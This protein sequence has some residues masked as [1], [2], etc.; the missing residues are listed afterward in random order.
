MLQVR[1]KIKISRHILLV[2][3]VTEKVTFVKSKP[4]QEEFPFRRCPEPFLKAVKAIVDIRLV[5]REKR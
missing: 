2:L 4:G 3:F 5:L 1:P